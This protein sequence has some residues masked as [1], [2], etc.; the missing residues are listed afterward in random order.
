MGRGSCGERERTTSSDIKTAQNL[1]LRV[2]VRISEL[3]E[4]PGLVNKCICSTYGAR[5]FCLSCSQCFR[6][7]LQSF[8]PPALSGEVQPTYRNR[9]R[10]TGAPEARQ[11]VA[12]PGRAGNDDIQNSE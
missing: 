6:T 1:G 11:S 3:V 2:C 9:S 8:V 7:G 12:Q 4:F 10:Q 5:K